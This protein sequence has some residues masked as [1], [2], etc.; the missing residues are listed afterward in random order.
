M[1]FVVVVICFLNWKGSGHSTKSH[2]ISKSLEAG[3]T[4][5]SKGWKCTQSE[6]PEQGEVMRNVRYC[7][8]QAL[9]YSENCFC[10]EEI[11]L[12]KIYCP[13]NLSSK[14]GP[15]KNEIC[16]S[17]HSCHFYTFTSKQKVGFYGG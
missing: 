15:Y 9:K 3:Q 6:T 13:Q 10:Y 5:V 8:Q 17:P 16:I 14:A 1:V 12:R 11:I 4:G 2:C 7:A